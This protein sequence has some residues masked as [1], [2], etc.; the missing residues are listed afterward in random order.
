MNNLTK[1]ELLF[2][3]DLV[4]DFHTRKEKSFLSVIFLT[5]LDSESNLLKEFRENSEGLYE[6]LL[7]QSD[8]L[9]Y[10]VDGCFVGKYKDTFWGTGSEGELT[11]IGKKLH[12]LPYV[13]ISNATDVEDEQKVIHYFNIC[14]QIDYIQYKEDYKTFC[15]QY[16]LVYEESFDFVLE[17]RSEFENNLNDLK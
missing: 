15:L 7:M 11:S 5:T 8:L 3:N 4:D 6:P 10:S 14:Y 13:L 16:G 1:N 12:N 17:G 2:W 9:F